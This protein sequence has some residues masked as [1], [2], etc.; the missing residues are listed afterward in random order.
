MSFLEVWNIIKAI[1]AEIPY[2]VIIIGLIIA[3][4]YVSRELNQKLNKNQEYMINIEG[5]FDQL[6]GNFKTM[7]QDATEESSIMLLKLLIIN[8]SIPRSARLEYYDEYK[9]LGGNSFVDDYVKNNLIG[10]ALF[11]GRRKDDYPT[12]R[13]D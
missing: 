5:S 11:Y 10:D 8:K 2:Q 9:K 13:Q 3:F 1:N 12:E 7:V 4:I 6:C